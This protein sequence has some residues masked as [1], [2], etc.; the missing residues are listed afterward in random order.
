[1]QVSK[2]AGVLTLAGITYVAFTPA[3]AGQPD[4]WIITGPFAAAKVTGGPWTLSQAKDPSHMATLAEPRKG[5]CNGT[6]VSAHVGTDL[7][8]PYYF[9]L[10]FGTDRKMVGY[11]DYR[12]KDNEEMVAVGTSRDG[13]MNWLIKGTALQL[14]DGKCGTSGLTDNGQGHAA[15]ITVGR[16]THLYTLDRAATPSFLLEHAIDPKNDNPLI[17]LPASEPVNGNT[18]PQHAML[19]TGLIAPDGILGV[20]PDYHAAGAG[21][22]TVEVLYLSKQKGYYGTIDTDPAHACPSDSVAT[23][24]L[25]LLGKSPNQDRPELH[26]AHTSDGINFTD[27]GAVS[28]DKINPSDTNMSFTSTRFIGPHGTVLS[29]KDGSYGLFFSGGNCGDGDSDAYHYIGYAHSKDAVHWTVDNDINNPLVSVDYG[30]M[31]TSDSIRHRY[32]GRV[33]SPGVTLNPNGKSAT[34]ILSGYNTPQPL[35]KVGTT[36][37]LPAPGNYTPVSVQSADYRS[38][39]IVNLQRGSAPKPAHANDE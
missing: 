2:I 30:N 22:D 4:P 37:G 6:S 21:E 12:V 18:V 26:L 5:M 1:M 10:I 8:Q 19:V 33:Y 23:A 39:M 24:Q 14:N 38:I 15:V 9:P 17:G 36:L 13:G 3:N 16:T 31:G 27:D 32:T 7:M 28:F 29:Y 20:V 25:K 11:F 35:P 34:L